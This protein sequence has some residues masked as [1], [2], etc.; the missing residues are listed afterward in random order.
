MATENQL[1]LASH[2]KAKARRLRREAHELS[3]LAAKLEQDLEA[4]TTHEEDTADGN[5][6]EDQSTG[7]QR[8]EARNSGRSP[9]LA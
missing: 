2:M 4:D 9:A 7:D 8:T 1:A 3:Q 5:S 6:R